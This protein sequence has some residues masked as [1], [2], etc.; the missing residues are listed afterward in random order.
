M[1]LKHYNRKIALLI[2]LICLSL[3]CVIFYLY[4]SRSNI[5]QI[6]QVSSSPRIFIFTCENRPIVNGEYDF[7]TLSALINFVYAH[8]YKYTFRYFH[9]NYNN[10]RKLAQNVRWPP[11]C[12]N[13]ILNQERSVHWAKLQ[14]SIY[15]KKRY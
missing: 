12:F 15:K 2:I 5:Y 13:Q 14:V 6:R 7:Y 4:T 9:M 3:I 1:L 10:T 8:Q 11:S